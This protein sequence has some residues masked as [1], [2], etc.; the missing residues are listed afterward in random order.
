MLKLKWK[1]KRR[2][3]DQTLNRTITWDDEPGTNF[4]S[5]SITANLKKNF[6]NN[7]FTNSALIGKEGGN[8]HLK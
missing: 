7:S 5:T 4:I 2:A 3:N 8:H 6:E 1:L